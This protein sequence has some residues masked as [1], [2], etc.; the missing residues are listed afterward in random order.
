M[1]LAK[2]ASLWIDGPLS[3]L[4]NA[5]LTSFVRFGHNV[6]LFTYGSI[7]NAPEGVTVRDA[8]EIWDNDQIIVHKKAKSPAIHAD[9]FR[10]VM[11][12]TTDLVW[13][14]TDVIALR[15]LPKAMKWFFGYEMEGKISNAVMGGPS[16]S[17]TFKK[18]ANILTDPYPVPG[19]FN[20]KG[21]IEFQRRRE[22]KIPVD[23]SSMPWGVTGPQ[24]LTY[25]AQESGEIEYAQLGHVFF[26]VSFQSRKLLIDGRKLEEMERTVANDE[27]MAVHLYSRWMRKVTS[28]G[29]PS[30]NSWIGQYLLRNNL[31]DEVDMP[32]LI[33]KEKKAKVSIEKV[34]SRT[35]YDDLNARKANYAGKLIPTRHGNLVAVTMAKDEGPYILEWVA[36]HTLLGFSDI[37]VYTN[38]CTDGTNEM[39]DALASIGLVS[40]YDN[41][42][43]GG[44]PPQSRALLRAQH[45]PLVQDANWVM[46]MDFDEFVMIRRG[47]NRVDDL[48]DMAKEA[49]ATAVAMTWRFFGSDGNA[50]YKDEPV[51]V[52][53]SRSATTEFVKGFGVKTLFKMD[54]KMKLA[55]HRPHF[56]REARKDTSSRNLNWINGSAEPID[57]LVMTWR[58]TRTT[59]GYDF[60][61]VN[62]YGVKSGEEYLMRRL[63]GDVLNNHEKYND[64]YFRTFDRNETI[65]VMPEDMQER[66]RLFIEELMEYP[67]IS[68]AANL[69]KERYAIKL[70]QLRASAGYYD[71]IEALGFSSKV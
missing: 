11:V 31:V 44:K 7:P 4:E 19:W 41:P 35:F 62:H 47:N 27:T 48:V 63:R 49:G 38:D 39:L 50:R 56:T 25:C 12:A 65:S 21:Q 37:L 40:R 45:H 32:Q 46:V 13:V 61:Q 54:G 28:G 2:I 30:S 18:L 6:T 67:E 70:A 1:E 34:T 64:D 26:P 43:I 24:A 10:A 15:P 23:W 20:K 55:I 9:I 33:K 59:A 69:I 66:L 68:A 57:G 51:T 58:Q 3:W 29:L 71:Q 17:R 16:S 52:R 5:S 22:D 8:R 42:P 53:F 60:C 14:D 36:H